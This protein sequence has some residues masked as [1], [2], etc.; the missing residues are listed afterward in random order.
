[1]LGCLGAA[2]AWSIA[3]LI[4]FRAV[5]GAGAALFP[6]SF[7]I[8]R[9]EFPP[10]KVKVGIGLMSAVFGVG[11]GFGIVLSGVIVDHLSWRYLFLLGFAPDDVAIVLIRRY[12]PESPVACSARGRR[13]RGAAARR[14]ALLPLMVALTE[15]ESWGW[16]SARIVG[17]FALSAASFGVWGDRGAPH[18]VR[19]WS[20]CRCSRTARSCSRT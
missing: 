20:T 16:T 15:G 18:D 4:A 8:I 19:R 3:S 6:L 14:P 9:D 13:P 5:A 2:T 11:G 17:L 10:E 1:M 12:V 7:A